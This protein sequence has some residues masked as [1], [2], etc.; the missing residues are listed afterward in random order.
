MKGDTIISGITYHKIYKQGMW[1][2]GNFD[3]TAIAYGS[4]VYY[5]SCLP[6]VYSSAYFGAIRNDTL[7]KKVFYYQ[8]SASSETLLYDFSLAV[9]DTSIVQAGV[10]TSIDSVLVN[11]NYRKRFNYSGLSTVEGIGNASLGGADLFYFNDEEWSKESFICFWQ[12][13]VFM[14]GDSTCSEISSIKQVVQK[15]DK[16]NIYPNP[17]TDILNV[18]CLMVNGTTE[19]TMV[20]MLGNTVKQMSFSTQHVTFNIID[21]SEG[22]YFI[23]L[24]TNEGILTKKL[25][26]QR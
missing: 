10:V 7:H 3:S 4:T 8:M 12:N 2:Y 23:N 5:T 9:G 25:I 20:D 18:E 19:I 26:V 1:S 16:V 21:L 22:V 13:D 17:A 24:K 14:Y 15:T 6:P 11:G